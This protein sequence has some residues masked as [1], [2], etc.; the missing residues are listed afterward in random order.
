LLAEI[1]AGN[2]G[3]AAEV[4]RAYF[5]P[6]VAIFSGVAGAIKDLSRGDVLASTK[7][8]NNDFGKDTS[9]DFNGVYYCDTPASYI[10]YFDESGKICDSKVV[11]IAGNVSVPKK[12]DRF[13]K[14]WIRVPLDYDLSSFH[15]MDCEAGRG[16]FKNIDKVKFDTAYIVPSMIDL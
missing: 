4:E 16:D 12:W 13:S 11:S 10:G 6:Q 15:A 14:G 1:G 5:N 3:A 7:V 9:S 2:E 8:Y